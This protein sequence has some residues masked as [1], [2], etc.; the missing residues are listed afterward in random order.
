MTGR[1]LR[2]ILKKRYISKIIYLTPLDK[3]RHASFQNLYT[4]IALHKKERADELGFEIRKIPL[5]GSTDDIFRT[6]VDGSR[7]TH[8]LLLGAAGYGKTTTL[9]KLAH[10]WAQKED[11]PLAKEFL[12]VFL[13]Q[14]RGTHQDISL[15]EVICTQL[16]YDLIAVTPA[17]I[18]QFI[19]ANANHCGFLLDGYDEFS[20]TI[21]C[22][23]AKSTFVKLAACEDF[24]GSRVL[25]STR[26]YRQADFETEKLIT[27][28]A[29]M[30][31]EGYST[32]NA[33]KYVF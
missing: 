5:E 26:Q 28:Y 33:E 19:R 30:E 31:L 23:G 9:A 15:G 25:V 3:T 24:P 27:M 20:G 12:F 18:E 6:K 13:L 2:S 32:E 16:L 8:I 7:P 1:S 10:D 4:R 22:K 29:T 14:F 21:A 17:G 11:S